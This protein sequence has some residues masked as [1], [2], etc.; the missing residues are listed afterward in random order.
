M[1]IDSVG[2]LPPD[3]WPLRSLWCRYLTFSP[4]FRRSGGWKL[5]KARRRIGS[6][7]SNVSSERSLNQESNAFQR[8]S[9]CNI[10]RPLP[11]S[12]PSIQDAAWS[13]GVTNER[14]RR[15]KRWNVSSSRTFC[16]RSKRQHRPRTKPWIVSRSASRRKICCHS[17]RC[18]WLSSS[19][20]LSCTLS[21]LPTIAW[22]ASSSSEEHA[23]GRPITMRSNNPLMT[24]STW[25]ARVWRTSL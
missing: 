3:C 6:K 1:L 19:I 11:R 17:P 7:A 15:V 13:A 2:S 24:G 5:A 16:S 9:W 8:L 4:I 10:R 23:P 18:S 22:D 12:T 25:S 14:A 20:T 21:M